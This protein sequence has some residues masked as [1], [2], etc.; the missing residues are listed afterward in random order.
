[1]VGG[2]VGL[3]FS[4]CTGG[5]VFFW[6]APCTRLSQWIAPTRGYLD[7]LL[8]PTNANVHP[9][10]PSAEFFP[11]LFCFIAFSGVS[12]QVEFKNTKQTF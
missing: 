10:S 11:D 7:L 1:M 6:A 9:Q 12:Q 3:G 8:L 4:K 5:S 2:W